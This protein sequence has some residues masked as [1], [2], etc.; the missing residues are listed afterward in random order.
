MGIK[1]PQIE[2]ANTAGAICTPQLAKDIQHE[3]NVRRVRSMY[4]QTE[5]TSACFQ[6]L[7][8]DTNETLQDSIGFI[9]D[10]VEVKIKYL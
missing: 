3:L 4:G 9:S 6:S 1:L 8:D 7:P 2:I 5:V 10:H